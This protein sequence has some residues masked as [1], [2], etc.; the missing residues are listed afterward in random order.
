MMNKFIILFSLFLFFSCNKIRYEKE[1]A[2]ALLESGISPLELFDGGIPLEDLYGKTYKGGLLFYIDTDN[3]Y[4]NLDGLIAALN[5]QD[6]NK[7]AWGCDAMDIEGL[8]FSGSISTPEV[9]EGAKIGEGKNNTDLILKSCEQENIAAR[10]IRDYGEEWSL[11]SREELTM[12]Y[13]NLHIKGHG[14][15]QD[16]FYWSSTILD[17]FNSWYMKFEDGERYYEGRKRLKKVRAVK[18]F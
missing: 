6:E 1:Q 18:Y 8:A 17:S 5:D 14:N 3:N 4:D 13:E 11:P 12:M 16:E 9:F 15:F 10:V 7:L 2:Q